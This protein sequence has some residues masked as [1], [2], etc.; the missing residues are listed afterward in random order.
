[1]ARP[2]RFQNP[3]Q[4]VA[5][6]VGVGHQMAAAHIE[7]LDLVEE[8]AEMLFDGFQRLSQVLGPRLAEHV[9]VQSLDTRGKL[10][11]LLRGDAQPRPR[12]AGVVE[13]GLHGRVLRVDPQA[14]RDAADQRPLAEP[15]E[16]REGVES[17][18]VAATQDFVDIAIRI[19]GRI[20]VRR[21]AELF[22]DEPRFGGRTGRRTV[23]VPR[24]IRKDAPHGAGLQRHD[25]FR[26]RLPAHP[27]D[28][29][30]VPVEQL[31][32]EDIAR[33]GDFS[34]VDH[35]KRF[36]VKTVAK[37]AKSPRTAIGSTGIVN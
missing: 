33:G 9:E 1:M 27:V 34:K 22:T 2:E 13:V 17:D 4:L 14:A 5:V 23:G 36:Q 32:V 21:A 20:G 37:V 24:Q 28:D 16:L 11:Q 3:D 30:K 19:D 15:F 18:M 10:R 8:S 7:P 25:D 6:V 29:R 35:R 12:H 26:A 31:L